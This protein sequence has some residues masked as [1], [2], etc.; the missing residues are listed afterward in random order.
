VMHVFC[1]RL[2]IWQVAVL[3]V[4]SVCML[5]AV[6]G[7][8]HPRNRAA[9]SFA[10]HLP[11]VGTCTDQHLVQGISSSSK[12]MSRGRVPCGTCCCSNTGGPILVPCCC[13][14]LC[15][16][17]TLQHSCPAAASAT[18]FKLLHIASSR[19]QQPTPLGLLPHLHVLCCLHDKHTQYWA[20]DQATM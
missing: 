18:S 2:P 16:L 13:P 20:S 6:L 3:V 5:W 10:S 19:H 8:V 17:R 1:C 15:L 7:Y 11:K 9:K 4:L 14:L 12:D